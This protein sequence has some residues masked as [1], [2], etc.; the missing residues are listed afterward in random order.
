MHTSDTTA[1]PAQQRTGHTRPARLADFFRYHGLWA[2]GV[3]LFRRLHF[4]AK[5]LILSAMFIIPIVLLSW[6][7]FGDKQ[8]MIDFTAGER[9]GVAALEDFVDVQHALVEVRAAQVAEADRMAGAAA[10]WRVGIEN[11]P[12]RRGLR[13][14]L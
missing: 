7:Y 14:G 12:S 8:A 3:R 1:R 9:D 11:N 6:Q 5:A 2:P 13:I 4:R 10:T